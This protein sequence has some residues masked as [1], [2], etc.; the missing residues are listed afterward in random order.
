MASF[1]PLSTFFTKNLYYIQW[2]IEI[3]E[4]TSLWLLSK[5][6]ILPKV[7]KLVQF[8]YCKFL[9]KN[10]LWRQIRQTFKDTLKKLVKSWDN[11]DL[12]FLVFFSKSLLCS[13]EDFVKS[14]WDIF[15]FLRNILINIFLICL[16]VL[17][18]ILILFCHLSYDCAHWEIKLFCSTHL[19][20]E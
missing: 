19:Q 14:I 5:L 15:V 8:T 1:W 4:L 6:N 12:S 11:K 7:C 18:L 3:S 20:K 10:L 17:F 13:C 16:E 9:G 2:L